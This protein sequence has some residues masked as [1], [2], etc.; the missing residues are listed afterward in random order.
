MLCKELYGLNV[1]HLVIPHDRRSC[2][3]LRRSNVPLCGYQHLSVYTPPEYIRA[4][5]EPAR[6]VQSST[7]QQYSSSRTLESCPSFTQN[8]PLYCNPCNPSSLI[9]VVC[10]QNFRLL[11]SYYPSSRPG[12]GLPLPG[13]GPLQLLLFYFLKFTVVLLFLSF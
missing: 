6:P 4:P 2:K 12:K 13:S 10:P 7:A 1:P 3:G 11:V 8:P 5:A 9:H